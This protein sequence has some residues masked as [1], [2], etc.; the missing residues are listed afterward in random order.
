MTA[1]EDAHLGVA[2]ALLEEIFQQV[3]IPDYLLRSDPRPQPH[4]EAVLL[5]GQPGAGKSTVAAGLQRQF[6]DQGGLVW[7]TWDDFRPFHPDYE[8]LLRERP[9]DMPDVTRPAARWWHEHAAEFLRQGRYHT[10]L[11]GGFRDPAQVMGTAERFAQAGYAV[12]VCALAVPAALSRLGII[13]R[14]AR[15]V[16]TAG[17]GRWT[18]AA[19]HDADYAGTLTVLRLAEASPVVTRL[20]VLTRDGL[21]FDDH[22]DSSGAWRLG[23]SA[24]AV[25]VEGREGPLNRLQRVALTNRLSDTL[26]QL[27][28]AGRT[29]P[30]LEE[31]ATVVERDLA[32]AQLAPELPA[33]LAEMPSPAAVPEP[34][35]GPMVR[36]DRHPDL[37]RP[38]EPPGRSL[39]L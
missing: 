32:V 17:V 37:R 18:T 5:G 26:A 29:H 38:P 10:L 19:S 39:E 24:V 6:A 8:R 13:E 27:R 20:S 31:M 30:A 12:R 2:R 22:R 35:I 21:V 28:R 23:S 25:L 1:P 3:I 33:V 14:Y 7:V 9:A 16:Q 34:G 15:Q 4:P 11:E 36:S